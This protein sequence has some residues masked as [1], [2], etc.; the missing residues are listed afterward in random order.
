[1]LQEAGFTPLEVVQAATTNGAHAI[2]DPKGVEP[3]IG[4]VARACSPTW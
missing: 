1:M 2:Y 3:P 4:M